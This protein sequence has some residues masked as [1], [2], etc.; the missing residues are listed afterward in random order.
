MPV[1]SLDKH[2][3]KFTLFVKLSTYYTN[4]QPRCSYLWESA[5]LYHHKYK[6]IYMLEKG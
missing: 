5:I 3:L 4:K 1:I 6:A 2:F